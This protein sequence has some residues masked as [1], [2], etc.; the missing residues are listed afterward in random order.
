MKY[1]KIIKDNNF[2]SIVVYLKNNSNGVDNFLIEIDRI[3]NDRFNSYEFI[4]VNDNCTDTLINNIK[5][6]LI[7]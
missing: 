3:L 7:F 2:I 1:D 6:H 5:K 4:L